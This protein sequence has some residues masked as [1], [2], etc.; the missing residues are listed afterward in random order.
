MQKSTDASSNHTKNCGSQIDHDKC[1]LSAVGN[2][3]SSNADEHVVKKGK[4]IKDMMKYHL[5]R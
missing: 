3:D 1:V 4:F 2:I 5:R